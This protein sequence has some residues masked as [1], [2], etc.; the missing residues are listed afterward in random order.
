MARKRL[1]LPDHAFCA[2]IAQ[3]LDAVFDVSVDLPARNAI[4][5]R[6]RD[7]DAAFLSVLD[8]ARD[9]SDYTI[10]PGSAISSSAATETITLHFRESIRTVRTL[11][12]NPA[13]P[14]EVVLARIVLAEEFDVEPVIVPVDGS[15]PHMLQKADGAL[16]V[17]NASLLASHTRRGAIDLVE[18]WSAI[19]DLPYVF[20][21]WC[22]REGALTADEIARLHRQ[23][24]NARSADN[25]HTPGAETL[26]ADEKAKRR[27]LQAF[28]YTLDDQVRAGI[29]RYIEYAYYHGVLPDIADLTFF[30]SSDHSLHGPLPSSN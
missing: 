26:F 8:Y 24:A 23:H 15:L 1:A 12:V 17:G 19:T 7:L 3:G 29:K 14:A 11:A 6:E 13:T 2:P 22:S 16:L 21:I 27:Y 18:V 5:L 25:V 20:G 4:R 10:V 9:S 28:A 30:P